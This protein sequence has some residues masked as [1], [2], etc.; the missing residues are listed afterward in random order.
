MAFRAAVQTDHIFVDQLASLS[1]KQTS[2]GNTPQEIQDSTGNSSDGR[3]CYSECTSCTSSTHHAGNNDSSAS[4]N[5]G[6]GT[7]CTGRMKRIRN[8]GTV[9]TKDF[10][11]DN[12]SFFQVIK[13]A[14]EAAGVQDT[15]PFAPLPT[16]GVPWVNTRG[17]LPEFRLLPVQSEE[18]GQAPVTLV[19][20]GGAVFFR[21]FG[22]G[23]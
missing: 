3:S 1:A 22:E 5:P 7:D 20:A 19:G 2:G 6:S 4:G 15:L 12:N 10:R 11:H 13:P 23:V 17:L 8:R 14:T 16:E 9:W 18:P 21:G